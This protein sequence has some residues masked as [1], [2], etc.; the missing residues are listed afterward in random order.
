[1]TTERQELRE[2]LLGQLRT[3]AAD[4]LDGRLFA[5]DDLVRDLQDEQ[6]ALMEDFLCDRLTGSEAA[7]F[8]AQMARSPSLQ[9]KVSSLRIYLEAL[10]RQSTRVPHPSAPRFPRL[11]LWVSSALAVMLCLAIGMYVNETRRSSKI[12]DELIALSRVAQPIYP[13]IG[14]SSVAVAFLS[15][16]VVRGPSTTPEIAM[17][18]TSAILELQIE[19]MGPARKGDTWYAE[20][21]RGDEVIWKSYHMSA[22]QIGH[23]TYLAL[24]MD[25][26]GV[27]PGTYEVRYAPM[28]DQ[29]A[30]QSRVFQVIEHR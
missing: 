2:Y 6:D 24:F 15:A 18:A 3:D 5:Q 17:P 26:G 27:R 23:E 21:R 16:N 7:S 19:M 11:L 9:E 13:S 8:R 10:K 1:M 30:F 28:S 14:P 29:G 20:V 25:A 22:H 12:N 4:E